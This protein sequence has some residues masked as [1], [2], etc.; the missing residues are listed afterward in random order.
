MIK[1][2]YD[3]LQQIVYAHPSRPIC[4]VT[5]SDLTETE[6]LGTSPY[7]VILAPKVD[8][9]PAIAVRARYAW[10]GALWLWESMGRPEESV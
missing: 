1:A 6:L 4:S 10:Q 9:T 8:F 2:L 3:T 5:L 7:D